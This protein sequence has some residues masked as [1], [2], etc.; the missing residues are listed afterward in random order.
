MFFPTNEYSTKAI[1]PAVSAF[2]HPSTCFEAGLLLDGLGLFASGTDVR[3]KAELL[4][5]V[6]NLVEIVIVARSI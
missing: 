3:G 2:Y 1:H 4:D 5:D 6:A